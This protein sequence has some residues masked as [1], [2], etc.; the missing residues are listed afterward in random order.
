MNWLLY[1]L[2][3]LLIG[4]VIGSIL[5]WGKKKFNREIVRRWGGSIVIVSTILTIIINPEIE[6]TRQ[7]FAILIGG[8]AIL[9]FGIWDD[10][11]RISWK[12][13]LA[14]QFFLALFLIWIGFDIGHI[15]L[16]DDIVVNLNFFYINF[17]GVYV[18]LIASVVFVIWMIAVI[19]AIN[20]LDG[21]DGLSGFVSVLALLAIFVVSLRP[22]VN[23]PAIAIIS[24]IVIGA[25]LSFLSFNFFH[26]SLIAGTSGSYFFGFI[27]ATLAVIS[28]TKIAALMLIIIIPLIDAVWVIFDRIK[29]KQSIFVGDNHSRHLHYRLIKL[30]WSEQKVV[31]VYALFL[32]II[33]IIDFYLQ[34]RSF[35][36]L[37]LVVEIG[38]IISFMYYV[39]K[40]ELIKKYGK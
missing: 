26:S 24:L 10:F 30:G 8:V 23:Q 27:L 3:A 5:F 18:Y 35:K 20:W 32:A 21:I 39:Y 13:Q 16:F 14:F 7:I 33:L 17:F 38:I 2:E 37:L 31:F 29:N 12:Y 9:F 1:F 40:K 34:S 4:A 11:K 36:L 25:L 15:K 22:E 28:G 6:I 19:N